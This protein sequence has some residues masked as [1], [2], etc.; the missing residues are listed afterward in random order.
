MPSSIQKK[1]RPSME[2]VARKVGVSRATVSYVL[3]DVPNANIPNETQARIWEAVKE[4]GYRP[5]AIAK[6]L[7]GMKSNVVGFITDDISDTPFTIDII[8]GAQ[9]VAL[10]NDKMILTMDSGKNPTTEKKIFHK[11]MEWQVEG[12]IFATTLHREISTAPHFFDTPTILVDCFSKNDDLPSFVPNEEQGGFV[13]TEALLKKGHQR[14]GFINGPQNLPASIG[15]FKGYRKALEDFR[16]SFDPHLI[17]YGDWWQESGYDQTIELMALENPPTGIFCAND[18]MA[19]GAYDALKKL[20][21]SIPKDVSV[22]GF[23]N[24]E[25]IASHMHPALTTVALPYYEMGAKAMEYLLSSRN[26]THPVKVV[27]D[28]PLIIRESV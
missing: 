16:I 21:L 23:D 6:G 12:I 2:D 19:M 17:R 27:L 9:D 1:K 8:K 25:V 5:N 3:N 20:G 14:I 24:R 18:W 15:R 26:P 13:A 22:I 10:A 4:L 11:V 28:C 7:R